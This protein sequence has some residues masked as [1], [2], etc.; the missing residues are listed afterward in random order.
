MLGDEALGDEALGDEVLGDEVLGDEVL[1][2]K[3][4]GDE[5]PGR[6]W[7]TQAVSTNHKP[8]TKIRLAFSA[9]LPVPS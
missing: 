9:T 3:A 7:E 4:L 6:A 5:G 1:R 2:G 8:A